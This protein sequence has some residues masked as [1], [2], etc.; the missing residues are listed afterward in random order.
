MMIGIIEWVS[1]F[2]MSKFW[3]KNCKLLHI[4]FIIM[5][6]QH[7]THPKMVTHL[8]HLPISISAKN[9]HSLLTIQNGVRATPNS[10]VEIPICRCNAEIIDIFTPGIWA[11]T[12]FAYN[13]CMQYSPPRLR[14]QWM[15]GKC[16]AR[17]ATCMLSDSHTSPLP[18]LAS[19]KSTPLRPRWINDR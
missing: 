13:V 5:G 4:Y 7:V 2:L 12:C 10:A 8:T 15:D 9:N 1:S 14:L 6:Q 19:S 18:S 17:P 3:E 11:Y 16:S